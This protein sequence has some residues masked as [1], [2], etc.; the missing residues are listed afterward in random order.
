MEE[1]EREVWIGEAQGE[2]EREQLVFWEG[3]Y[4]QCVSEA[5]LLIL[6]F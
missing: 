6:G 5:S 1:R 2:R 3:S 4:S